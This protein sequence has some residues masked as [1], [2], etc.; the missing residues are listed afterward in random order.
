MID[1]R[2]A[3]NNLLKAWGV[4]LIPLLT[5]LFLTI[6]TCGASCSWTP[7]S[8]AAPPLSMMVLVFFNRDEKNRK[9]SKDVYRLT[10]VLTAAFLAL[11]SAALLSASFSSD[12]LDPAN[13]IVPAFERFDQLLTFMLGLVMAGLGVVFSKKN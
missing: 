11:I 4:G 13:S 2:K 10:M 8:Y 1:L 12:A 5:W 3:Q 7:L 9:I 6:H